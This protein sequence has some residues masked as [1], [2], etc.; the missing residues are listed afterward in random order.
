M[1]PTLHTRAVAAPTLG[2]LNELMQ[3]PEI[4]DFALAG[5]TALALHKGHRIS[6]DLDFF[7][8]QSFDAEALERDL[9]S[10]LA[11]R[12]LQQQG[13]ARNTLSLS[14]DGVKSD[15]I[16]YDYPLL[17]PLQTVETIRLYSLS[18]IAAMK[19]SAIAGRGA[20]KDFY[21]LDC[22]LDDFSPLE[23]LAFFEAKFTTDTFHLLKSLT[24]F[25][26]ADAEPDPHSLR[27]RS[28][29]AIKSR[30]RTATAHL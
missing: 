10:V 9:R 4:R 14:I 30:I 23:L 24:F 2:L 29:S 15:L 25:D 12:V 7:T 6:V 20:K 8:T 3:L 21:D 28:W 16:R 5:G 27:N 19:L 22:L 1:L 26:D 11:P 13:I 18:D 17:A